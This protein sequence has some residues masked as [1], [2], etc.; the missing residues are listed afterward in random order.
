MLPV[1]EREVCARKTYRPAPT[2]PRPRWRRE[3]AVPDGSRSDHYRSAMC[4]AEHL[5]SSTLACIGQSESNR[6]ALDK[7]S[8]DLQGSGCRYWLDLG[9]AEMDANVSCQSGKKMI[10]SVGR[11]GVAGNAYDAGQVGVS[12]S[13]SLCPSGEVFVYNVCV[14]FQSTASNVCDYFCAFF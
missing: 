14:Y 9:A 6:V 2:L 5:A 4:F 7:P 3:P 12:Q 10:R 11:E 8:P 1:R 13:V